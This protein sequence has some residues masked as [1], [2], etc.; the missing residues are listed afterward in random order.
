MVIKMTSSLVILHVILWT[1]ISPPPVVT[2]IKLEPDGGYTGLVFKIH[3]DVPEDMC[4]DI[5]QRMKV[6]QMIFGFV[7]YVKHQPSIYV[8][9]MSHFESKKCKTYWQFIGAVSKCP[10]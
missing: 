9:V 5:I 8:N 2:S 4:E 1:V 7:Y 3:K 10:L 6:R